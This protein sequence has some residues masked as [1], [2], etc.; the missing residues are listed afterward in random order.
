MQCALSFGQPKNHRLSLSKAMFVGKK[1]ITSVSEA[2]PE[3]A[4]CM[5]RDGQSSP[6]MV[7][8]GF[9]VDGADSSDEKLLFEVSQ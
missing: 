4:F 2:S 5:L 3:T 9:Y 1:K 8:I 7:N 6:G